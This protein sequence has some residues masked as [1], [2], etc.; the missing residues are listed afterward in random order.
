MKL[1]VGRGSGACSISAMAL[2][3]V[4]GTVAPRGWPPQVP[5]EVAGPN[6][7]FHQEFEALAVIGLVA[8][9]PVIVAS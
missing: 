1:M 4:G 5:S 6:Q 9:V 3:A 8:M 2:S 7:L